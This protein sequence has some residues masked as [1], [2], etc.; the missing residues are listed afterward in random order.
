MVDKKDQEKLDSLRERLYSRGEAVSSHSKFSLQDEKI[1]VPTSFDSQETTIA[2]S[3][4]VSLHPPV[5]LS[6]KAVEEVELSRQN[7]PPLMTRSNKRQSYRLKMLLI[8]LFFFVV[9]V[10]VSSLFIMFG[11]RSIS[12]ENIAISITGPF[13]IGGGETIPLQIGITNQNSV[14]IESATLLVE[15]PL[16]TQADTEDSQELF[17][18][19]LPLNTIASGEAVNIPL[20]AKVFG[21]E[22]QELLIRASVEYRVSG[23]NATFYKEAEPLR[24]KISSSPI[25]VSVESLKNVSSGQAT[26]VKLKVTSNAPTK[27]TDILI[28]AEYPE[29]FDF[30]R[31]DP[32]SVSGQNVWLI[33]S[34]EPESSKTITISGVITGS[35][36]EE[37]V[38]N[39]SVGVP[40]ERDRFNLASVY[41]VAKAEFLI[42]QP[43]I[44]MG[45]TVN[46]QR[47]S[48]AAISP[49]DQSSISV[50]LKNTLEDSIY[51]S[52]V[53]LKL[54][55]NALSD[56]EVK[57]SNGFYN[58]NTNTIVWDISSIPG[59]ERILPG[60]SETFTFSLT[61]RTDTL[62][63]PQ[64]NIDG[65]VKARRVSDSSAE[66]KLVGT[67]K[68]V[69]K[70][71]SGVELTSATGYN[72]D[73]FTD[74]GPVPPVVGKN[75]TYTISLGINNGS[76]EISNTVVNATL[77][78]YV[79]WTGETAGSGSFEYNPATR[80]VDWKVDTLKANAQ[81]NGYFQVSI[82][83]SVSQIDKTPTI[84]GEQRLKADDNFTGTVIRTTTSA[85]T[86]ELP[87]TAGYSSQSG[88]VQATEN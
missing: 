41:S 16:G 31:S 66:E 10:G 60:N 19:R 32:A 44:D 82:L 8:G 65:A 3:T 51:D 67:I 59:L 70:V 71:E 4:P 46:G 48:T 18:E 2:V 30:T 42:E 80:V 87:A 34:L 81:A 78:S 28:K 5:E 29:G 73:A 72:I 56:T 9:S 23:S 6:T 7:P 40:N 36:S 63:T 17:V 88:N 35:Q 79:T 84:V 77:P 1:S 38:M 85:L 76:N 22:N 55:G 15:Y 86:T 33:D 14:P 45:I 26:E 13:T 75:T 47:N 21:E 53:E 69:I 24:F 50:E 61:P 57:V 39:F 20:R 43:F 12:G 68:S 37:Y 27:L 64:I 11:G 58:S 49:G 83:P 25:V 62:F 74:V 54:S 52:V